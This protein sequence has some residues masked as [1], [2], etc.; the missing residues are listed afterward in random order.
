MCVA[1]APPSAA[2]SLGAGTSADSGYA[3]ST[4][5]ADALE[6][7]GTSARAPASSDGA[8]AAPVTVTLNC[9]TN[10]ETTRIRNNDPSRAVVV[11]SVGSLYQPRS[12]EPFAVGRTLAP[13][14]GVTFESSAAADANVLSWRYIYSDG[15]HAEGARVVTS[16]G[17]VSASCPVFDGT[18]AAIDAATRERMVGS[19]WREGCPVRIEDL[20]LLRV[21]YWGFD[22]REHRGELVVSAYRAPAI[23]GAMRRLFDARF[24]IERMELVDAYGADDDASMA[25]NNTSAFNCRE[26][27]GRPGVWSEH[28]YGRAID[29]NPVQNPYISASGAVLPPAGAEYADRSQRRMGMIRAGDPVVRAFEAV[30]WRWGGYWTS[31]KDYQHFSATGR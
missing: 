12:D 29:I 26:V 10:P 27:T 16:A 1:A 6:P 21:D 30:G 23:L 28:S 31:P 20:R 5:R 13:G 24:R 7:A 22:G 11:R 17:T 3:G 14:A 8:A 18:A 4:S 25:A 9:A 19:S 2:A 15:V